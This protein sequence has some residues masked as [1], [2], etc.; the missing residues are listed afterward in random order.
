MDTITFDHVTFSY[1]LAEK[2][3][4]DDI[5][6][7]VRP[8]EFIVL[9]GKSGCGKTTL[10]RHMKKNLMPYGRREGTVCYEGTEISQV[11][12]RRN[13]A[14]IG[15]VQQNPD[16]QIVT[17]K[18]W[19]ELA[20]GLESL[21]LSTRAIRR[22]V[23][24]MASYFD[25]QTWFRKEVSQLSGGQKQLLNLAS[26]MVMQPKLLVLDEPT[27]QLDPIAAGEFLRTVY[28]I[29]RE[30]GTTVLLSE[31]RL[32]EVFPLA[33]RVL[34]MEK[35]RLL[36]DGAPR[37]V[38]EALGRA[39]H[40]MF[41]AMPA[42][43]RIWAAVD[44]PLPCPV[45]V[46]EGRDWL[47]AFAQDHPLTPPPPEP[48]PAPD[49]ET[50]LSLDQVWFR[51]EKEGPDVVKGL[52]L[53]L[54][55]GEFLAILGG[56]G[57]GKSTTLGLIAGLHRPYRGRVRCEAALG[58]LAQDPQTLF[59]KKTVREDL[60]EALSGLGLPKEERQRR[61]ERMTRLC[62]LGDLLE[63]HPYDLSGGEQQRLALAKVLLPGPRL[64]L[65]DEPTKG[66][67]AEFK[68]VL[69]QILYSLTRQGLGVLM[70]SHD[71]EFCAEYAHRCALFFDGSI[72]SQGPPQRFF[73]EN[74][75]YTTTSNRMSRGLLSGAVTPGQVAAACGGKL[76][77]GTDLLEPEEPEP[78]PEPSLPAPVKKPP[79]SPFR[80]ALA[81]FAGLGT[82]SGAAWA[83]TRPGVAEAT[84]QGLAPY[85]VE[86]AFLFL[87]CLAVSRKS[88]PPPRLEPAKRRL[89]RRTRLAL[90]LILL[91]I[92]LTLY[93]GARFF[94]GRK[95]LF[96]S[97]L[98][99]LE[100]MT[101][102]ALVFEGRKPQPRE[103]VV[104]AALC[105]LGVVGRLAFFM[106]PQFKPVTAL[107]ILAGV[108]FGGESGF[109]VGALTMLVS[110]M[111][112]S[113]GP[114]TPWQMFA[115]GSIGFLAG[116][117]FRKGWL[118]RGRLALSI[119]GGVASVALYGGIMNPAAA[120]LS[121]EVLNKEIL[122]AYY[123]T[124][125]PV[126]LV[127]GAAT[128]LFLWLLAEPLLEKLDRIK[129][130]YGLIE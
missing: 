28:K 99:L 39:D 90:V 38:G 19:H 124:G 11:D 115:M 77:P 67:D 97:L 26:I 104:I 114:W 42:P 64:L 79:L 107:V 7:S 85:G 84:W 93:I 43:M 52:S 27:S 112:F 2:A 44:N 50:L 4:L 49:G 51:Y 61:L 105:G 117:L 37:E 41:A 119:F 53:T 80:R 57:A 12:D 22:R 70:V 129:V 89:S 58:M 122:L 83:I 101:P 62:R 63:R 16:N 20:F 96:I 55:Q 76:P 25:I 130:K 71:V 91:A 8:S 14:E 30:L 66:L 69:A 35:G 21:G 78:L 40:A 29:N 54:K 109:L 1:P 56:N 18:V 87:L 3:A 13:A 48:E 17:D 9:A 100:T 59:V 23:A 36:A 65:L 106:L 116:V 88:P 82:L 15:F 46:R 95:Y 33:D 103:L 110:N 113:Q 120:I 74:S 111:L 94:G 108:A 118:N 125:F 60:A 102:F 68:Q 81:I 127:H 31:H 6:F 98:I 32:E 126:D 72:V 121:Q 5:S 75:F 92:P 45:T 73:G 34:V 128:A 86:L 47:A 24:E 10:L 123:A